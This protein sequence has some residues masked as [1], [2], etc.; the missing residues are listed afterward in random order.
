MDALEEVAVQAPNRITPLAYDVTDIAADA[1]TRL[2]AG[3]S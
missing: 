2:D 1:A 3:R